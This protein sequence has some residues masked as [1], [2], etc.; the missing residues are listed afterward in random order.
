MPMPGDQRPPGPGNPGARTA[1][2]A[3]SV[4]PHLRIA[5]KSAR[6]LL[7]RHLTQAGA[8]FV[9]VIKAYLDGNTGQ[10]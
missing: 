7:E 9:A 4:G 6:M 10:G 2:V 3:G 5:A 1:W 8:S